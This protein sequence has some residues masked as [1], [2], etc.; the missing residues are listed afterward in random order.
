MEEIF[1]L[2]PPRFSESGMAWRGEYLMLNTSDSPNAG[3]AC[4][5]SEVLE[6]LYPYECYSTNQLPQWFTGELERRTYGHHVSFHFHSGLR[7]SSMEISRFLSA[8]AQ[9]HLRVLTVRECE[10]LQGFPD[11]WTLCDTGR[12]A[13]PFQFKL[14]NGSGDD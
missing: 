1:S 11:D 3:V 8:H 14:S 10:R 2:Q 7:A 4:G 9:I 6:D 5:L 13:T 12:S